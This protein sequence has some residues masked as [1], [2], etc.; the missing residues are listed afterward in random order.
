MLTRFREIQV[1]L[2]PLRALIIIAIETIG[3]LLE[4]FRRPYASK[5]GTV[6]KDMPNGIYYYVLYCFL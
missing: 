6:L 3:S 5:R 2:L 4:V 1:L